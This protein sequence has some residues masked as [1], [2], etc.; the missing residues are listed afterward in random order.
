LQRLQNKFSTPLEIFQGAN[1]F[2]T[3]IWLLNFRIVYEYITKLC[4]QQAEVHQNYENANVRIILQGETRH[5]KYK[6]IKLGGGQA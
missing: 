2:A 3:C 1:R 4:R 6:S 5:R